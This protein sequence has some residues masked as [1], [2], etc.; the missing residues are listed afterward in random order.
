[1]SAIRVSQ[2]GL[3][4]DEFSSLSAAYAVLS[5]HGQWQW[6][7]LSHIVMY[8]VCCRD[9][10]RELGIDAYIARIT[11]EV[12][13]IAGDADGLEYLRRCY[14]K[15]G[16]VAPYDIQCY[17][18]RDRITILG[19]EFEGLEDVKRHRTHSINC[20]SSLGGDVLRNAEAWPDMAICE[21]YENY[22]RFDIYDSC[23]DRT[24]QNYF[25]RCGGT[26]SDDDMNRLAKLPH[27]MNLQMVHEHIHADNLPVLYY[28]GTG[29][30]MLLATAKV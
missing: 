21:V 28:K 8:N 4:Y 26:F 5:F 25:F 3:M 17:G 7:T 22:P 10:L 24:Y 16:G 20:L 9:Q 30:Y 15:S 11:S 23:D 13:E 19:R 1:M 2:Y 6:Y 12:P 18:I 29:E 14:E 27:E